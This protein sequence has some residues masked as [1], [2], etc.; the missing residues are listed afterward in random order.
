MARALILGASGLARSLRAQGHAVRCLA[1]NP[2]RLK[3]LAL[4]G[5]EII[6]GDVCD[7]A[8]VEH[9]V[10]SVQPARPDRG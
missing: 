6:R 8:S 9:A 7:R 4:S 10:D 3:E 5:C 1:R 2:D